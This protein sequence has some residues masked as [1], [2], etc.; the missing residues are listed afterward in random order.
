MAFEALHVWYLG[1]LQA[2][3]PGEIR[4][5]LAAHSPYDQ[6]CTHGSTP[7]SPGSR[8]PFMLTTQAFHR[9]PGSRCSQT[10]MDEKNISILHTDCDCF[11]CERLEHCFTYW[12][13]L[14]KSEILFYTLTVIDSAVKDWNTVSHSDCESLNCKKNWHIVSNI[15]HDCDCERL[16]HCFTH[17]LWLFPPQ[18]TR[19]LFYTLTVT[20]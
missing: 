12:L 1:V 6:V 2:W 20:V 5:V 11:H 10:P 7:T 16:K 19:T 8:K 3:Y 18:K 13:W 17:W 14:Y 15:D 9:R 4:M